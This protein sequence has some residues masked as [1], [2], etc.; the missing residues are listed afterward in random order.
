M[1]LTKLF[2]KLY[3][4]REDSHISK[5]MQSLEILASLKDLY[6]GFCM[7]QF[8]TIQNTPVQELFVVG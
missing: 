5:R 7:R 6:F 8:Q 4:Y 3:K 2:F 1:K